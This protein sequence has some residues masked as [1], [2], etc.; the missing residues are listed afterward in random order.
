[1]IDRGGGI[2]LSDHVFLQTGV[3]SRD[4]L[5]Y[6]LCKSTPVLWQ[7]RQHKT[8]FK[9]VHSR[10]E[11]DCFAG[12]PETWRPALRCL[13]YVMLCQAVR[14][15]WTHAG[16]LCKSRSLYRY[17][18]TSQGLATEGPSSPWDRFHWHIISAGPVPEV[19]SF[20]RVKR[21]H[22]KTPVITPIMMCTVVFNWVVSISFVRGLLPSKPFESMWEDERPLLVTI[23]NTSSSQHPSQLHKMKSDRTKLN[24][25]ALKQATRLWGW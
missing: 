23:Y 17:C 20:N 4:R 11:P 9:A 15:A 5:C 7:L 12:R 19:D 14:L 13:Q 18:V 21:R 6:C 10:L 1:M 3:Q 24:E 22:N 2:H 25:T 8:Y 16:R